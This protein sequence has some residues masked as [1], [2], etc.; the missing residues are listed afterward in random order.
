M[1]LV[2]FSNQNLLL[3]YFFLFIELLY[4][5]LFAFELNIILELYLPTSFILLHESISDFQ[6]VKVVGRVSIKKSS[7][8]HSIPIGTNH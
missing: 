8:Q 6:I 3:L 7:I 2:I 5:F 4:I 1:M